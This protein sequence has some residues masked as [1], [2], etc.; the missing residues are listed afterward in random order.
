MVEIYKEQYGKSP[1]IEAV[2]AGVECGLF[3]GKISG[4]D[5]VS[6]GPNLLEIH[7]YRERMDI[8]SARRVYAFTRR[9]IEDL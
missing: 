6:Y 8:E 2:H 7:T 9:V 4:L 3:A 5:C 1:V